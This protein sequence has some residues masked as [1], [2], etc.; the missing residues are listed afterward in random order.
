M[1]EEFR[2]GFDYYVSLRSLDHN[3]Q[4]RNF[5]KPR[6]ERSHL[7]LKSYRATSLQW[8]QMVLQDAKKLTTHLDSPQST[9]ARESA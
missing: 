1:E 9:R 2:I 5:F 3:K 8:G 7:L 6:S 4:I